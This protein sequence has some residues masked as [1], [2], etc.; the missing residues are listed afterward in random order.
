MVQPCGR[1][2]LQQTRTHT[3]TLD[4]APVLNENDGDVGDLTHKFLLVFSHWGYYF[5]LNLFFCRYTSF[6]EGITVFHGTTDLSE[7]ATINQCNFMVTYPE[8]CLLHWTVVWLPK[9]TQIKDIS[10]QIAVTCLDPW[11]KLKFDWLS[12]VSWHNAYPRHIMREFITYSDF[13]AS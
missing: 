5:I 8:K 2:Q 12:R 11:A 10:T 7:S 6:I 9:V 1:P 3:H 4:L 13:F